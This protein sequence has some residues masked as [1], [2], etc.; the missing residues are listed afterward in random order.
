VPAYHG[1]IV[2]KDHVGNIVNLAK[3]LSTKHADILYE[4]RFRIGSAQKALNLYLK[5]LWCVGEIPAP[6]HCPFDSQIVARLPGYEHIRWTRLDEIDMYEKLVKA[7]RD[8]A[9]RVGKT[10]PVWELEMYNGTTSEAQSD[11]GR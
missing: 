9:D 2:D 10:L 5:Y 6:P 11:S 7:A 1:P 3:E 8:L 4:G